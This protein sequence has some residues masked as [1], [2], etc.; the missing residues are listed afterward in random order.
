MGKSRINPVIKH[1]AFTLIE[2]LVVIAIISL[3][4]A[5]LLPGLKKIKEAARCTVCRT[6]L[7]GV[8][9]AILAYLEENGQRS[10][11]SSTSNRFDWFDESG[12]YLSPDDVEAYWAVAYKEYADDPQ[13]F[14]CP[15]WINVGALIYETINP[16][17]D[18]YAG[19][20]LNSNF[21]DRKTSAIKQASGFIVTHDHVEP[22][23]E[24]A[25]RD[26]LY[27]EESAYNLTQYRGGGSRSE[28]YWGIFRH[29][30]RSL[31]LDDQANAAARIPQI[32]EFPNGLLNV[33]WLDGHVDFIRETTGKNVLK[34]WYTGGD[35]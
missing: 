16:E 33:L 13:V 31:A 34:S 17:A 28:H 15:S 18:K 29:K 25:S 2:L 24:G 35:E 11:D 10:Y 4:L 27:I 20:G 6:H 8:G 32:N 23:M 7:K 12:N 22:K 30:K 5:I 3:L 14:G 19:Y 21:S 1:R 26:M 9:L